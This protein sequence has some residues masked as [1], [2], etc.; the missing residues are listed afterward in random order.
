M[1]PGNPSLVIIHVKGKS[2][3]DNKSLPGAAVHHS[4]H[5][6]PH[7]YWS[8]CFHWSA[9]QRPKSSMSAICFNQM[10]QVLRSTYH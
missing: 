10:W 2:T 9:I 7:Y 3:S 6:W 5:C 4:N 1:K 8:G